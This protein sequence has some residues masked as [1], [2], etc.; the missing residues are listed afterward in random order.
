MLWQRCHTLVLHQT[1]FQ[2]HSSPI[3]QRSKRDWS[4]TPSAPR[5]ANTRP[6]QFANQDKVEVDDALIYLLH[7]AR[8]SM[9]IMF[10][11]FSNTS[12]GNSSVTFHT[13]YISLQIQHRG[14]PSAEILWWL[15]N[16]WMHG[17]YSEYR[18]AVD[19]FVDWCELNQQQLNINKA[20]D[21]VMDL[22][23]LEIFQEIS[24][25]AHGR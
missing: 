2:L 6:L 11:D 4:W 5:Q 19:S 7:Q 14:L 8:G 15:S 12:S 3:A 23:N 20:K 21:P 1:T 9:R 24:W 13:V 16:S 10:L 22:K 25:C 17:D 18:M